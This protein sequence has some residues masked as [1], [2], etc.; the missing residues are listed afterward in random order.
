MVIVTTHAGLTNMM[1]MPR[2]GL[3]VELATQVN[4][5]VLPVCGYYGPLGALCGHH[6][7]LYA[8]NRKDDPPI[9]TELLATEVRAFYSKLQIVNYM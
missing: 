8:Y 1:F 2:G 6:H 9:D 3:V 5:A 7:Y 4:P